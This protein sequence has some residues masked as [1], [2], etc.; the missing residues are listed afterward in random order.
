M[1]IRRAIRNPQPCYSAATQRP[2]AN[3][4]PSREDQMPS[5]IPS[6]PPAGEDREP[7]KRT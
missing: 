1:G 5:D 3:N 2:G 7:E 6:D 4:S